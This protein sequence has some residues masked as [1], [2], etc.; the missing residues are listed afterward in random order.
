MK[1]RGI[2]ILGILVLIIA[3]GLIFGLWFCN[4][5]HAKIYRVHEFSLRLEENKE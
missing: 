1:T 4:Q 2:L 3:L 5:E